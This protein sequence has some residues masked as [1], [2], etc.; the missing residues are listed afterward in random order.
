MCVCVYVN[1]FMHWLTNKKN[2]T[3][4]VNDTD[5]ISGTGI[6]QVKQGSVCHGCYYHVINMEKVGRVLLVLV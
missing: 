6:K 4:H 2:N 5:K 1:E 3:A